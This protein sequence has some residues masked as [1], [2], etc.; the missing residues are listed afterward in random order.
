MKK[1]CTFNSNPM[2]VCIHARIATYSF[3]FDRHDFTFV[4]IV[5]LYYQHQHIYFALHESMRASLQIFMLVGSSK[6]FKKRQQQHASHT[7]PVSM[8][9]PMHDLN[10]SI[11]IY[12]LH[13]QKFITNNNG[14]FF[15][16]KLIVITYTRPSI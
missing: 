8:S 13:V 16:N 2:S 11:Q 9:M 10:D 3:E 7:M 15:E 6:W 12:H 4:Q 1:N 14:F 5:I